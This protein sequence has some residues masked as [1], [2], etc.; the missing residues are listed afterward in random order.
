MARPVTNR[1]TD[2]LLKGTSRDEPLQDG[3]R[4]PFGANG[5]ALSHSAPLRGQYGQ[6]GAHQDPDQGRRTPWTSRSS[7]P[8]RIRRHACRS[9]APTASLWTPTGA[10]L[11]RATG[12]RA[13]PGRDR[14][15]QSSRSP[16]AACSMGPRA[17]RSRRWAR[18]GTPSSPTSGSSRCC[19]LRPPGLSLLSSR[20]APVIVASLRAGRIQRRVRVWW[21]LDSSFLPMPSQR[22]TICCPR[23]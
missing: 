1:L 6:G 8:R 14:R 22:M 4:H 18:R 15:Q 5:L 9:R 17:S 19:R 11:S 10:S 3:P 23:G 2:P 21:I 13:R 20:P 16:W 7:S 12:Q